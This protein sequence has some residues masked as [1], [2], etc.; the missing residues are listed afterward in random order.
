[1]KV[2][3]LLKTYLIFSPYSSHREHLSGVFTGCP[4][5]NE[6]RLTRGSIVLAATLAFVE[7]D[8]RRHRS[9]G[10]EYASGWHGA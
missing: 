1:M 7:L 8:V 5:G 9:R 4:G 6:S 3:L 2:A 10:N